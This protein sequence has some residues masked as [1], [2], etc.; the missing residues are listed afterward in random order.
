MNLTPYLITDRIHLE[1]NLDL[2]VK[3]LAINLLKKNM[4]IVLCTRTQ[5]SIRQHTGSTHL[6]I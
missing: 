6:K 1:W 3:S 4:R 5:K 2:N